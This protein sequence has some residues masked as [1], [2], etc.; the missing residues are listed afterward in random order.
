MSV[1]ERIKQALRREAADL[2]EWKDETLGRANRGL[3]RA[4]RRI[5]PDPNLRLEATLDDI[6]ESEDE[7][8]A[9][10]RKAEGKAARAEADEDDTR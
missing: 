7:F 8:E 10:R 2:K 1:W 6:A 9:V 5:H 4:E 3:D